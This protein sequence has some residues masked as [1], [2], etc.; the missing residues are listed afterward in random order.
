MGTFG[1]GQ[2]HQILEDV[3]RAGI[4]GLVP[5]LVARIELVELQVPHA[6]IWIPIEFGRPVLIVDGIALEPLLEP[7]GTHDVVIGHRV[8][9]VESILDS[10]L[11]AES[12]LEVGAHAG[13][14]VAIVIED[15]VVL[16]APGLEDVGVG[17]IGLDEIILPVFFVEEEDL[18]LGLGLLYWHTGTSP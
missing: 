13:A 1:V 2:L 4:G 18:G 17:V 3:V 6:S 10:F 8:E 15:F 16:E 14:G 11:G 9:R 5:L 12:D 7:H